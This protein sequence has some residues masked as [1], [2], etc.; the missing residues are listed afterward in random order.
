[1]NETNE[2]ENTPQNPND[3]FN[4]SNYDTEEGIVTQFNIFFENY[5][6]VLRIIFLSVDPSKVLGIGSLAT[7]ANEGDL[8][9]VNINVN[10]CFYLNLSIH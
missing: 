1:M 10:D 9:G 7:F 4:F 6:H 8:E 3:E 2:T 5:Y